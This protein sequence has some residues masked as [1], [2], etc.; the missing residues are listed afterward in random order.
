MAKYFTDDFADWSTDWTARYNTSTP[1]WA[2]ALSSGNIVVPGSTVSDWSANTWNDVEDSNHAEVE[3]LALISASNLVASQRVFVLRASGADESATHVHFTIFSSSHSIGY[4]DASDT[5]TNIATHSVT[6]STNTDYWVRVRIS[7]TGTPTY[8]TKV[9]SGAAGDEPGGVESDTS[10]NLNSTNT[11]IPDAAGWVGISFTGVNAA[12]T[13]K[14][15]GVGTN[16]DK[17]PSSAQSGVTWVP[18]P[19]IRNFAAHLAQ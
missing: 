15:F 5:R 4:C 17:A 9:W 8:K 2:A 12:T 14:Q 16:G 13:V 7:G 11:N 19:H 1:N 3:I 10:W 18:N 6:Y